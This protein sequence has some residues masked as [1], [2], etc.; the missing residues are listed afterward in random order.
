MSPSSNAGAREPVLAAWGAGVDSTAM[1]IE[2]VERGE[3]VDH[4]LFA[5]TGGER[6]STLAFIPVFRAWLRAR[7]VESTIVRYAPRRY[8]NWPAYR[9]LTE[10]L[11]TNGT[12]PSVAFGRGSCS[13]KWK[14]APQHSWASGWP[15]AVEAWAAGR[16]VVK[17]IGFDCSRRDLQRYAEAERIPSDLYRFRYPLQEWG[18]TRED[19]EARI[20]AA[21][22]GPVQKSACFYCVAM[23]P[24]EVRALPPAQLRQIVLIEARAEPR[25]RNVEGL[26]RHA[27]KGRRTGE[28]RPG[29]MTELIRGEGLLPAPEVEAIR[30]VAPR[31]LQRWQAAV[32]RTP[33]P[34]PEAARWLTLFDAFA[35]QPWRIDQ[36]PGLYDGLAEARP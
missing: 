4:V 19:C 36:A 14:Q 29:S 13:I 18:W 22:L 15:P 27:V 33:G 32:A 7:G 12:L 25:L 31:S 26:W 2:L 17:L 16:K 11:I 24:A 10:N 20:A 1:L 5:D 8:K 6:P 9:T 23:K 3:P 21:G 28:A 30:E 35:S 34:R